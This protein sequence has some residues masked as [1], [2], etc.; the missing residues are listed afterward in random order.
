[1]TDFKDFIQQVKRANDIAD[2]V[3]SYLELRPKGAALFARCPFHGEKT[4]SFSV[5]R[6]M[7]IYHCFGCGESGDVV[8]F[9]QQYESCTLMEA[10]EILAKRAGIKMPETREQAQDK[11]YQE[12]KRK[13]DEYFAIC[14]DAAV[15]YFKNFYAPQGQIAREYMSGR[16]FDDATLK[17]FGIGYSPDRFSLVKFLQGKKYERQYEKISRYVLEHKE[18]SVLFLELGV[19]RMGDDVLS[20]EQVN[21]PNRSGVTDF[22]TGHQY[23]VVIMG[24]GTVWAW[25]DILYGS[26]R[27]KNDPCHVETLD[28]TGVHTVTCSDQR[29][30]CLFLAGSGS[31]GA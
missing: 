17:K 6:N 25:G 31:F 10:L 7:Q 3:G 4:A 22:A 13:R 20:P 27:P 14:R 15:F 5:N 8:K 26:T 9:V 24:D 30:F 28:G 2:V 19:G 21:L 29:N 1:M 12:K 11:Q 23:S 16:G 18:S